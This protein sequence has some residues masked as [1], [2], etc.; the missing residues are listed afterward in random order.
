MKTKCNKCIFKITDENN[1]QT[2]CQLGV[3]DRIVNKLQLLYNKDNLEVDETTNSYII[4][5]FYCPYARLAEWASVVQDNNPTD[6][7]LENIVL[8]ESTINYYLLVFL[9]SSDKNYINKTLDNINNLVS[10]PRLISFI[11]R[12]TN[13]NIKDNVAKYIEEYNLPIKWKIHF[14]VDDTSDNM[15]LDSVLR[16]GLPPIAALIFVIK[17]DFTTEQ[18]DS[19]QEIFKHCINKK[20]IVSEQLTDRDFQKLAIPTSFYTAMDKNIDFVIDEIHR[21][22]D[23]YNIEII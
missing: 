4:N 19:S 11:I 9:S 5:D 10:K 15:I 2:S 13:T 1:K 21:V 22:T 6:E 14:V 7:S 16:T 17:N 12:K 18:I 8:K 3:T 20:I 23:L